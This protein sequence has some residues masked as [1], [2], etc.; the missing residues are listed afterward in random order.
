MQEWLRERATILRYTYTENLAQIQF[1]YRQ[2]FQVCESNME[3]AFRL[4]L[5]FHSG[6]LR[7]V[8][9]LFIIL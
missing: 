7:K 8:L 6:V 9:C 4:L 3:H 1:T 5:S 2:Y